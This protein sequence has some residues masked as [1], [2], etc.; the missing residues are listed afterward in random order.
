MTWDALVRIQ[1]LTPYKARE[2]EGINSQGDNLEE[3]KFNQ[4]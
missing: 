1:K 4:R 2:E 3:L